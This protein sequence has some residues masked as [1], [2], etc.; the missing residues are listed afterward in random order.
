MGDLGKDKSFNGSPLLST[1]PANP[2][3]LVAKSLF[4]DSYMVYKGTKEESLSAS[5]N[6]TIN[7]TDIA[8]ASDKEYKFK[9]IQTVP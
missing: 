4:T 5:N 1:E 3:G 9:R 2:C 8:W 7:D 6:Q